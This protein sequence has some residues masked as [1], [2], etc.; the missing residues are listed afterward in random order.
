MKKSILLF[1]GLFASL[2]AFSQNIQADLIINN[3][4]IV[5]VA[6]NK[7]LPQQSVV[8]IKDMIKAT[9]N[10][11]AIQKRYKAKSIIDGTGKFIMPSLWDMHVHFGGDTLIGENKLLLPLYT[12]MGISHVR[13]CAGDI[14]DSVIAW[15]NAIAE[16]KLEG[17]SIFTSGPKLEGIKSIWPGDLE[18]GN[19]Q[20]LNL[21]LDSL[22]QLKVDFVKITDNTLE[23]NLFLKSIVAA[24][25]RGWK[26]TGH[27][28]ATMTVATYANAG[29]SAI[30]HIGYLQRAASDKEDSITRLRASGKIT[31]KEAAVLYLNTFNKEVAIEKFKQLAVNGTAIVPTINGSFKTT[32]LDQFDFTKDDYLKYLGPAFKRTYGWRVNRAAGDNA[33]AI[34]FRHAN[35]EAA[36]SLLP[37]LYK[38]GVTILAGTDAG[39]LNSYNYPGLGMHEELEIMVKYGLTPQEALICSVVN[40]PAFFGLQDEYGGVYANKKADLLI[41]NANPLVQIQNTKQIFGFI[42]K[43][44]YLNRRD[45]DRLLEN[46]LGEVNKLK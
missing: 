9:G 44:K 41:L 11:A 18:I 30:E 42:K 27:I 6:N 17:P 12:A 40:G 1:G 21:A 7:I 8:I 5:D 4:N 46:V 29:L 19:E 16:N 28:P 24:K 20:E 34:K 38:S 22:Q 25:K 35:F 39:F 14:S 37:L 33:D 13:D 43:G 23:P 45:L 31:N 26:V 32:Y 36:A 15:K 10:T 3:I 2:I